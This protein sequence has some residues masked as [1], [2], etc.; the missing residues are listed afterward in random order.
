MATP[1]SLFL[2]V[3]TNR[4]TRVAWAEEQCVPRQGQKRLERF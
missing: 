2:M 3:C 4:K 1:G